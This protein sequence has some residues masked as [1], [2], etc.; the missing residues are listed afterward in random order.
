MNYQKTTDDCLTESE[1]GRNMSDADHKE[2]QIALVA[3]SMRNERRLERIEKLLIILSAATL[4]NA[5][6]LLLVQL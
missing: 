5:V 1:N 2:I 3:Q 4:F 6:T